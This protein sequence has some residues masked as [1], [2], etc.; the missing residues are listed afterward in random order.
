M[1]PLPL[2]YDRV[3]GNRLLGERVAPGVAL[4][5]LGL[6]LEE[7]LRDRGLERGE[8][9]GVVRLRDLEQ[10]VVVERAAQHGG[11]AQHLD[12][13]RIE[14]TD[15]QEHRLA[16]RLGHPQRVD[17]ASSP[18]GVGLDD[19]TPVDGL[20]EHLL[21]HERVALRALGDEARELRADLLRVQDGRDHLG[22]VR[23]GHGGDGDR[24]RQA[25]APPD[26]HRARQRMPP[27]ELVA[28]VGGQEHHAASREPPRRVVEELARRAVRPVDVVEHEEQASILGP[29]LQQ[30]HDRLEEP[31]LRLGGIALRR[32]GWAVREL[33]EELCQLAGRGPERR[34]ERSRILVGEV[35]ADRLDERQVRERELRLGAAAPEDVA[36]ELAG[37]AR[38][39]GREPRLADPG[40]TGEQREAAV[41][42]VRREEGVLELGQLLL[43]PDENG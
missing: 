26:L 22:H 23:R 17:R 5:G 42:P 35:V 43:P 25:G 16:D 27:V 11:G 10:Q 6:L 33:R 32:A 2:R 29:Q 1:D 30:R 18:A 15:A 34:A 36:A 13:L 19:L 20:S 21:E 9:A 38:Q 3:T 28:S 12:R 39:L 37:P 7:L 31:Q 40:L 14:P 41:P 24:L 4:A 8:H